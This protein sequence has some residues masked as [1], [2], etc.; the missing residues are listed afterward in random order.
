MPASS[1]MAVATASGLEQLI[2]T[3]SCA[4]SHG[5]LCAVDNPVA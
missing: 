4:R 1:G 2:S 3:A 5:G